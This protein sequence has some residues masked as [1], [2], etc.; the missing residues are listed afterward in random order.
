MRHRMKSFLS[1]VS[2]HAI[3]FKIAKSHIDF[4]LCLFCAG[5]AFI[6]IDLILF[7]QQV[8]FFY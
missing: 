4:F 6:F 8:C 7:E 1:N 2:L 3:K 5:C